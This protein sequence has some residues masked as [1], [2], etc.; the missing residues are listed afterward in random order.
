MLPDPFGIKSLRCSQLFELARSGRQV[1]DGRGFA[2]T[3]TETLGS[4]S[5][6]YVNARVAWVAIEFVIA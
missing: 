4:C 5:K 3:A 6:L 2:I 1:R